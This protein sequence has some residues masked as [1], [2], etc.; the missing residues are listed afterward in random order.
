M[1]PI[2]IRRYAWP[3]VVSPS[4]ATVQAYEPAQP[5]AAVQ[6]PHPPAQQRTGE[7]RDAGA[8]R[9]IDRVRT[10]RHQNGQQS[11]RQHQQLR[12]LPA[13]EETAHPG[14][15]PRSDAAF[16]HAPSMRPGRTGVECNMLMA[17]AVP[18]AVVAAEIAQ[19]TG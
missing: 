16:A 6:V 18:A 14:G 2:A 9:Q 19:I 7:S 10:H 12:R 8:Q 1:L 5:A 11:A 15:E 13:A 17:T 3:T 4:T